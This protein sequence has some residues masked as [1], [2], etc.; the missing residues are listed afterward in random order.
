MQHST[1][2]SG[3]QS[4][5]GQPVFWVSSTKMWYSMGRPNRSHSGFWLG[6]RPV[7]V[8][9]NS[10]ATSAYRHRHSTVWSRDGNPSAFTA[11]NTHRANSPSWPYFTAQGYRKI[12][13]TSKS[14]NTSA[15]MK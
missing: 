3:S 15:Y 14:R 12:V 6:T 13:S 1:L 7:T 5:R 11:K 9:V 10:T 4:W 8:A 2:S